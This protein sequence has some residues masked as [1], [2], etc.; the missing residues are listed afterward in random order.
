MHSHTHTPNNNN[1][2]KNN[3]NKNTLNKNKNKSLQTN[4]TSH[5]KHTLKFFIVHELFVFIRSSFTQQ[6]EG[7]DM[8]KVGQKSQRKVI[9][10]DKFK[11][12]K[13]YV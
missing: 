5:K 1:N 3:N 6:T 2:N 13:R 10:T 7:K 9:G 8:E 4:Q 11:D 12:Q